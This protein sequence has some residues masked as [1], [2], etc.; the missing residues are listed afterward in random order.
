MERTELVHLA[1]SINN[2]FTTPFMPLGF[3]EARVTDDDGFVLRIGA[4][5]L[6]V[7]Q[8]GSFLGQG[9]NLKVEWDIKGSKEN[10]GIS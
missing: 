4:R 8:D 3:V 5:D 6:Q 1:N 9:T 7:W 10:H 2:C